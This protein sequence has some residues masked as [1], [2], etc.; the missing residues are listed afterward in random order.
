M[1]RRTAHGKLSLIRVRL[2]VWLACDDDVVVLFLERLNYRRRLLFS[3]AFQPVFVVLGDVWLVKQLFVVLLRPWQQAGEEGPESV[4]DIGVQ[5]QVRELRPEGESPFAYHERARRPQQSQSRE[6][7]GYPCEHPENVAGQGATGFST[8]AHFIEGDIT[9][10]PAGLEKA[11]GTKSEYQQQVSGGPPSQQPV[12]DL[13][14][15]KRQSNVECSHRGEWDQHQSEQADDR[16]NA[17]DD[18][19]G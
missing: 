18:V 7:D 8:S 2:I 13:W 14:P 10:A 11:R 4:P 12:V 16:L 15:L 6:P 5:L 3:F 1:P 17:I 9:E 19:G